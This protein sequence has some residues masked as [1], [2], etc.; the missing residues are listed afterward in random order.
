MYLFIILYA[1]CSFLTTPFCDVNLGAEHYEFFL[2]KKP[3]YT[4]PARRIE[5]NM[6]NN[7]LDLVD[8]Q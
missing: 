7:S 3:A 6:K 1:R 2:Q 4:S 5:K 8:R